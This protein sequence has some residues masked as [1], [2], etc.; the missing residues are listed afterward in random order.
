M[1]V[2]ISILSIVTSIL[3]L[4]CAA[5][6]SVSYDRT[7]QILTNSA[8]PIVLTQVQS[9]TLF[10][11]HQRIHT[12]ALP[13]TAFS[14]YLLDLR[15]SQ[16]ALRKTSWFG[17][18]SGALTAVN[19]SYFDMD[20]GGSVTYLEI[21]DS[22]ICWTQPDVDSLKWA[23]P[24]SLINAA[25]I[26]TKSGHLVMEHARPDSAYALSREENAVLVAGPLLLQ[27]GQKVQ[28]PKAHFVADRHPRSYLAATQ[29]KILFISVD[30]RSKSA[31]GMSLYEAQ[32]YLLN[33]GCVDAI[34]LDGGGS[35]TLWVRDRGVV[36][37]PS[38]LTGERKVAN[39]FVILPR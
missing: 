28:M 5:T 15:Y 20:N 18:T 19:G 37:H 17:E 14:N 7:V 9:D 27:D 36:N 31:H 33:L 24:D 29:D 10:G 13:Q 4:N 8:H 12:V 2:K 3:F 34:N 21:Q 22:V 25:V 39:A 30:G 38:D 16:G 32:D 11:S 23:F 6:K 35:T 1:R 26:L